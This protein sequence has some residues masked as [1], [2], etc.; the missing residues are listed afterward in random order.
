V[1]RN[2]NI[3]GLYEATTWLYDTTQ[4]DLINI[5]LPI[6][7]GLAFEGAQLVDS[8]GLCLTSPI[9]SLPSEKEDPTVDRFMIYVDACVDYEG[10][11]GN[12]E[13]ID[14]VKRQ[15]WIIEDTE[16]TNEQVII[17]ATC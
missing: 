10:D 15:T 11:I 1:K 5:D 6:D 13:N 12:A 17:R 16:F 4:V 2:Q 9:D 8:E 14:A 3:P 7:L